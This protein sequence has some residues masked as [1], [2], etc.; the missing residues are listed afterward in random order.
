ML[1]WMNYKRIKIVRGN[2]SYLR[3]ADNTTLMAKKQRET[4][5]PLDE[6]EERK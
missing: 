6:G 5:E 1:G 4:K 3:Y 2:I